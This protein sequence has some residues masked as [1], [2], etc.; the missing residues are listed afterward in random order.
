[1]SAG[2][3]RELWPVLLMLSLAVLVP[4]AC[5]LWFMTQAMRNERLAVRQK[6]ED[7]YQGQLAGVR[8]RLDDFWSKKLDALANIDPKQPPAEVFAHLVNTGV[9]D[10]EVLFDDA[11]Q[12]RYPNQP[13]LGEA[14]DLEAWQDAEQ[15]EHVEANPAE[16]AASYATIAQQANDVN[17][18]ARALVAQARCLAKSGQRQVAIK[19]LTDTF[20]DPKYSD[21]IDPLGRLIVP[22][23]W[24]YALELIAD[25]SDPI[26]HQI[27]KQLQQRLIDYSDAAL[28]ATQRRF[29]MQRLME[30]LPEKPRFPTLDAEILAV[31]YVDARLLPTKPG[32]LM[33]SSID[34]VWQMASPDRTIV[35]L[36]DEDRLID[37]MRIAAL[38]EVSMTNA[39]VILAPATAASDGEPFL[40]MPVG[41]VLP[42]WQLSVYLQGDNP[43]AAAAEKRVAVYLWTGLLVV[44]V[45]AGLAVLIARH[46]GRQVKLTRLK[47]DLIA[48]VSHELKTPLSSIRVLVDTLIDNECSDET[49]T[50]EYLA[51]IAKENL[52]LS[53]LIDNFLTFSRMER[54]KRAFESREVS[55]AEVVTEAVEAVQ[56]RLDSA[57]FEL[58]VDVTQNLPQVS[59][60][61]DALVTVIINLLDNA[62]KYSKDDR[63]IE[64]NVYETDGSVYFNFADHGIGM[65]RRA[66]RRIFDRFYQVDQSLSRQAGGCGLGLSIVKFII[67]A[68]GGSISV[69][70]QPGKGSTFIV[71]LPMT[72]Q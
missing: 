37:Q 7:I 1:M 51:L 61:R 67:D 28:S 68:H 72:E 53:R 32:C 36:F 64:V 15:L 3:S 25:S 13:E 34:K 9:A 8:D 26:Y 18:A 33:R 30:L 58:S 48:T 35:G 14:I 57:G 62:I 12:I 49:Q 55:P 31:D 56:E 22:N 27:V 59:G 23:A 40:A 47:N 10:S 2:R 66:T 42:D 52:R 45:F 39:R 29:L 11:G 16:A 71:R 21:T 6:L 50:Q 20:A 54:N 70:S 60:D 24:L 63:R 41:E 43:F 46:L 17:L 69:D 4:T 38:S 19:I 5:V 44:L 65:S